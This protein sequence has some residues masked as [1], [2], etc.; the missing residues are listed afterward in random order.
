MIYF[1]SGQSRLFTDSFKIISV[2]ESIKLLSK[3]SVVGVD[4]ETEGFDPYTKKLL[5][6]Q[7][8]C[9]DFQV[10]IDCTTIDVTLYKEFLESD[11][12]FLF[13]NAKFD[14][15]FLYH[16]RIVPKSVWDGYL[17]E[18]LMW[19]G[20]PPGYHSMSLKSAGELYCNIELDKSVRGQ[21][22]YK[23]LTDDVII[24]G[25]TD[26]KYLEDIMNAQIIK[27]K[28]QDLLDAVEYENRFVRVLAYIE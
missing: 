10:V 20:Y 24:Y 2:E 3:L 4:T 19:L 7:L 9:K 28:E 13:W 12:L 5:S 27:L 23:G 17:A 6:L 26:V 18:K 25:A 15:K 11:R 14:L 22:I 21:I 1:V 16:Q 8:G